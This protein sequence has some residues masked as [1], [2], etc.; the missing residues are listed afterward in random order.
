MITF[1][2]SGSKR[3]NLFTCPECGTGVVAGEI[4]IR[5]HANS[6]RG[7]HGHH[8]NKCDTE[9]LIEVNMKMKANMYNKNGSL[10]ENAGYHRN[11][12]DDIF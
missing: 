6:Y 3:N 7:V 2:P 4:N 12:I 8:C 9:F 11:S 10:V 5:P 1:I